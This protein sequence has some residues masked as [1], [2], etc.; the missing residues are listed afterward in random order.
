MQYLVGFKSHS[1]ELNKAQPILYRLATGKEE[2]Q[3]HGI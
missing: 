2:R 1:V 3:Q